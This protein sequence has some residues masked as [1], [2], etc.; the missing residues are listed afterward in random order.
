MRGLGQGA[1][2][3]LATLTAGLACAVVAGLAVGREGLLG[4]AIG[5]ALVLGFLWSGI[6]PLLVVRGDAAA[7]AKGL[8]TG[9]LLL[10]YTLRLALALVV[11]KL[12]GGS[13]ALSQRA[14]G[15]TVI[16]TAAVWTLAQLVRGLRHPDPA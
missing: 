16:V 15:I 4:A 6:V 14:L 10:S 2:A 12:A 7:S 11:L 8:A 5:T 9:I 3:P 13:D 1:H